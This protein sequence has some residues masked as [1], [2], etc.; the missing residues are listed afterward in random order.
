MTK[1]R[2]HCIRKSKRPI[3]ART[4]DVFDRFGLEFAM[5]DAARSVAADQASDR[6]VRLVIKQIL[7]LHFQYGEAEVSLHQRHFVM[8]RRI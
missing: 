8:I 5:N 4:G 3:G 7:G 2:F 1:R 6:F